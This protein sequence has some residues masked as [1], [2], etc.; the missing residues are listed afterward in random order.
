MASYSDILFGKIVAKNGLATVQAIQECLQIQETSKARGVVMT[1]PEVMVARAVLTEDQAR[2]ASRA[3]ALT[4][5]QRAESI[6]AKICHEKGLVPFPI[7]QECFAE[8]KQKRFTVRISQL[9]LERRLLT[10]EQNEEIMEEQL[11]RL[12]EETRQQEEAGLTGST[13]LMDDS[14]V[15]RL[16]D[17]QSR[18]TDLNA[19]TFRTNK[20]AP[21]STAGGPALPQRPA[22]PQQEPAPRRTMK[23]Q[24][25]AGRRPND[26][27]EDSDGRTMELDVDP[28]YAGQAAAPIPVKELKQIPARSNQDA[29]PGAKAEPIDPANLVN[30]TISSRYRILQKLGEGGM[31][32]V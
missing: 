23:M 25:P 27:D 17:Q 14:G 28:V 6:Y 11:V 22:P 3:Q 32:T 5:L 24:P 8:Q 15:K 21:M 16:Q 7:L 12:G 29:R 1:L 9:L 20:F 4:Q 31:G 13:S 18:I 26:E 30:K 19:S 2:L 10:P